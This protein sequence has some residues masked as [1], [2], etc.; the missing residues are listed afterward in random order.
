MAV[1]EKELVVKAGR[2][3]SPGTMAL[4]FDGEQVEVPADILGKAQKV[5][6][7]HT[8]NLTARA[9]AYLERMEAAKSADKGESI[10]GV[11]VGPYVGFDIIVLSPIQFIGTPPYLPHKVVAGGEFVLAL[12]YMWTNPAVDIPNGF[13]TSAS[14][15]LGLRDYRVR[16]EQIDL[17]RVLNGP[18]FQ[19]DGTFGSPA[20]MLTPLPV[21]FVAPDPGSRPRLMEL[22]VTADIRT[23]VQPWAAFATNHFDIDQDPAFLGI[24]STSPGWRNGQPLRY[25]VYHD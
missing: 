2:A 15:Q 25:L 21:F 1:A 3:T 12:A 10:G 22:N 11:T 6:D 4:T 7:R 24:P 8:A 17:S 20:A 18:D 23:P 19:I 13:A 16:F 9:N 14:Q 5:I